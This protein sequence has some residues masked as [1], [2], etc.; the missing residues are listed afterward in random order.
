MTIEQILI[1]ARILDAK[2]FAQY[3]DAYKINWTMLDACLTNYN[4]DYF[5]LTL[6]DYD[7]CFISFYNGVFE[8]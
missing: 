1:Q 7:D 8:D 2:D 6:D 4:D 5:N 3:L